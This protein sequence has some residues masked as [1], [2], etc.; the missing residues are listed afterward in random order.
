MRTRL[1]F[2]CGA[3]TALVL[4][5][6]GG[7][8]TGAAT[9]E[10]IGGDLLTMLTDHALPAAAR[11]QMATTAMMDRKGRLM[12]QI[13]VAKGAKYADVRQAVKNAGAEIRSEMPSFHSGI[14]AAW[15][16]LN[17]I[18]AI[19]GAQG[20]R[21]VSM[22]HKPVR[23]VGL[24]T[25][26]GATILKSLQLNQMGHSGFGI[27]IGALSNSYNTYT[28]Y[29]AS[30][31][32]STGDLPGTGNPD[33]HKKNVV[34]LAEGPAG[35]D[36][37]RALLQ[38][39]AD[40]APD[41]K[42][43]FATAYS[44]DTEFAKNI[45]A[46][47]DKKGKCRADII[48][49]DV[50]YSDEPY[51]SDEN[52]ISAAV[53][54]VASQGVIYFSSAGN[55]NQGSYNATFNPIPAS[56]AVT[57]PNQ[58]VDLSTVPSALIAGG[59]HNFGTSSNPVISQWVETTPLGGGQEDLGILQWNDPFNLNAMTAN[60]VILIFDSK[61]KFQKGLSGIG[62]SIKADQPIQ[63]AQLPATLPT[64]YQVVL[65]KSTTTSSPATQLRWSSFYQA[66]TR[67]LTF[68]SDHSPSIYG[69]PAANG[70]IA[71]GAEFYGALGGTEY[72]S[73]QGPFTNY[74]DSSGNRLQ[75]PE[76]RNKPEIS[77]TDGVDTTFFP[78]GPGND[79]DGDGFPNFFGTSASAPHAAGIG[80]DLLQI[81][82]RGKITPAEMR[83]LLENSAG[84][85][86]LSPGLVEATTSDSTNKYKVAV[87][88]HGFQPQGYD[89]EQWQLAVSAPAGVTLNSISFDAFPSHNVFELPFLFGGSNNLT[90][91]QVTTS[92]TTVPSFGMT[93]NFAAG[94]AVSGTTL[95][96]SVDFDN[97][98][99]D[100]LGINTSLLA[101]TTFTAT[102]SDGTVTS[103]ATLAPTSTG[104]GW[105]WSDG[106]GLIDAVAAASQL[107]G[108]LTKR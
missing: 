101:G 4:A 79:A 57:L 84:T 2:V 53:N 16:N 81:A 105:T 32:V 106:Y 15:A 42:L 69:H 17:D 20:V 19:A 13:Y 102:F 59:V 58:T 3:A 40:T 6:A 67:Q 98:I 92:V 75:T 1:Q 52:P 18:P 48:D 87:L 25:S 36:E 91:S 41:A 23:H 96:F 100:Y 43:C 5:S 86:S 46:L 82:G 44:S 64:D 10:N 71:V 9:P 33:R 45:L 47:A 24:V 11:S 95:D 83:T 108:G 39:M 55:G 30:T 68:N 89:T 29:P 76:V 12:V 90:S 77:A 31:D 61:G 50:G 37:G 8:A 60:Y 49:D 66:D 94:A 27:T 88:V 54:Q 70:A 38:I 35:D 93:L 73:S 103:S 72:F 80:A 78:P 107:T 56:Q 104:T 65:A 7:A 85:H 51:F 97:A 26:Q 62:N 63:V 74:F 99:P 22:V 14:I 21:S 34:V 28:Q